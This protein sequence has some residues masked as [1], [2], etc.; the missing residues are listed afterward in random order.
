MKE[1]ENRHR[2][3]LGLDLVQDSWTR[4]EVCGVVLYHDGEFVRKQ[5]TS[6]FGNYSEWDLC[7]PVPPKYNK[8]IINKFKEKNGLYFYHSKYSD[9]SGFYIKIGNTKSQRTFIEDYTHN[10]EQ[11]LDKWAAD[12]TEHDLAD[13]E[14]FKTRPRVH[15]KFKEGDFF[16]FKISRRNW[17]FGRILYDIHNRRKSPEFKAGIN[18]GLVNLLGHALIVQVYHYISPTEVVDINFLK[19]RKS[20]PSQPIFH[21]RFFYGD[22]LIIG[23]AP[24]EESEITPMLSFGK[25]YE[26]QK[27]VASYLQF[28]LSYFE[29]DIL[30]IDGNYS[31]E[32][33]GFGLDVNEA[34]L[35]E[36]I[37]ANSNDPLWESSLTYTIKQDLRNPANADVRRKIFNHFGVKL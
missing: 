28:G 16:A 30:E 22:Y 29:S 21:N 10:L 31:R 26:C 5:I 7:A 25:R 24:I 17:G 35:K 33:V 4:L 18:Q 20:L 36:C 6:E 9:N 32:S 27:P 8:E 13:M 19:T 1:L 37:S 15:Q 23:N 3:Y 14:D 2:K 34:I 12:T 11:W